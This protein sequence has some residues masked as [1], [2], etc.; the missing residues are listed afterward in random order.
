MSIV[1]TRTD[2]SVT[3]G[4]GT[5][6]PAPA[7][8]ARRSVRLPWRGVVGVILALAVWELLAELQ[9]ISPHYL[10]TV[11]A[12]ASAL[13]DNA[14]SL[15]SAAKTTLVSALVGVALAGLAGAVV[16]LLTGYYRVLSEL[17]EWI[18]RGFRSIPS[19]AF[20]PVAILFFGLTRTMITYLVAIAC[21]WP[22]LVNAR[23]A[24]RNLP[25]EYRDAAAVLHLSTARFLLRVMLPACAP[26][27]VSGLKTSLGIALVAAV[28]AELI[29]GNGGLGGL[30]TSA[31]QMGSIALV[32]A[33]IVLGGWLGWV[34]TQ[35][36]G[37][38]EGR[39]LR[40]NYRSAHPR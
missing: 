15:A 34:I 23:Y 3:A 30:A 6:A 33:V 10:P 24:A 16:G 12:T 38:V 36:V 29:V 27:I 9:V 7:A 4:F 19:L 14:G 26:A 40:W 35:L 39:V 20:I 25:Q 5:G 21:F 11:Q 31:Q 13:A 22:V 28:S 18:V 17:T 37:V 1:T 8:T 2:T 32:Y